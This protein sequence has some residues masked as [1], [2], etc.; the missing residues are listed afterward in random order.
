MHLAHPWQEI[1]APRREDLFGHRLHDGRPP[2]QR[3]PQPGRRFGHPIN[4]PLPRQNRCRRYRDVTLPFGALVQLDL[5]SA[6]PQRL[7]K[8]TLMG[9]LITQ[10]PWA[11]RPLFQ[12][13]L[14]HR[15]VPPSQQPVQIARLPVKMVVA[16]RPQAHDLICNT[17][18]A[19]YHFRQR[20]D[21][22]IGPDCLAVLHPRRD[23]F[24]RNLRIR[25]NP[26]NHQRAEKIPLPALIDPKVRRIHLRLSH[27]L[28][29][30]FRDPQHLRLQDELHK[31]PQSPPLHHHLRP[32][33][34]DHHIHRIL[35]CCK[36]GPFLL[37]KGK[38]ALLQNSTKLPHLLH[39]QGFGISIRHRHSLRLAHLGGGARGKRRGAHLSFTRTGSSGPPSLKES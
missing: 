13:L 20:P 33:F 23:Q 26:R 29:A 7:L 35:L 25:I 3:N 8:H 30:Q 19:P 18:R 31:L 15:A 5:L 9:E 27:L 37:F 4:K 28:I 39:R 32:L 1:H 36:D 34:I 16:L 21:L 22:R 2:R 17:R 38:S 6:R 14:N 24:P 10:R 12:Q 11:I